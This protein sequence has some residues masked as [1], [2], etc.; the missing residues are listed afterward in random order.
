MNSDPLGH[1]AAAVKQIG[2]YLGHKVVSLNAAGAKDNRH[3]L[4]HGALHRRTQ[5]GA[6]HR[7]QDQSVWVLAQQILD[8]RHLG[9]GAAV[10]IRIQQFRHHILAQLV[11]MRPRVLVKECSPRIGGSLGGQG[12]AIGS[13]LLER[14]RIVR[15]ALAAHDAV[16]IGIFCSSS[17]RLGRGFFCGGRG[18]GRLS[19][20]LRSS[21]HWADGRTGPQQSY[22]HT[23]DDQH[24]KGS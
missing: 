6:A 20:R 13:V 12:D 10:G 3:A 17:G 21:W 2:A 7:H 14:S 19:C 4:G 5:C 11:Y 9:V 18:G 24:G 1:A 22:Q 15:L 8:L 23:Q 16:E